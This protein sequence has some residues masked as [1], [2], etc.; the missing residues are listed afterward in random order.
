MGLCQLIRRLIILCADTYGKSF[1]KELTNRMKNESLI[2]NYHVS[3]AKFYGPCNSKLNRQ[4]TVFAL[5]Q[6]FNFFIIV[7]D[8]DGKSQKRV[9]KTIECHVSKKLKASTRFV[10]LEYEIEDW[11]CA[12]K[13]MCIKGNK[14][15]AILRQKEG[16]EKYKLC[17]YVSQLDIAKLTKECGSFCRFMECL[18]A[19]A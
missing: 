4:I 16:Y 7:A 10:I 13:G 19:C 17:D 18:K 12:S 6:K 2:P 3:V 14:P 8:A 5:L 11:I 1:F 15:S 9:E